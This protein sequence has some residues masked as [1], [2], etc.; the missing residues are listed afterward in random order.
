MLF[1]SNMKGDIQG[2][3][4]KGDEKRARIIAA[5]KDE[6]IKKGYEEANLRDIG[7]AAGSTL[8]G[9]YRFFNGKEVLFSA[10]S[11]PAMQLFETYFTETMCAELPAFP[12]KIQESV[13]KF[14]ADAYADIDS[15]RLIACT[16]G[17]P[18][19]AVLR[20]KSATLGAQIAA[21]SALSAEA[22]ALLF[23]T[24][25]SALLE[26]ARKNLSQEKGIAA[27]QQLG[28]FLSAGWQQ[29]TAQ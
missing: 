15:L 6:F 17:A 7:A 16:A 29:A 12:A 8:G 4:A 18:C 28:G 23:Q 9:I 27:A 11:E 26:I 13:T 21:H 14:V 25:F 24:T 3:D 1:R 5:A 22:A 20:Q 19:E 2:M 10:L